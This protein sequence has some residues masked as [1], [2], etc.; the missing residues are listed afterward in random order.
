MRSKLEAEQ[1]IAGLWPAMDDPARHSFSDLTLCEAAKSRAV[2][3]RAWHTRDPGRRTPDRA[4]G[5]RS[6]HSHV[7]RISRHKAHL[8]RDGGQL[9]D[10]ESSRGTCE[11]MDLETGARRDRVPPGLV[12]GALAAGLALAGCGDSN[13]TKSQ[14]RPTSRPS[15]A[16]AAT[17]TATPA[18]SA[19]AGIPFR[20]RASDGVSLHGR[21]VPGGG[22]RAP[23]V[24]LV[25]E[26]DGGPAQFE[27]LIGYL[28][29]KG[30]ASLAY[31][32]R[33]G[34]A[35]LDETKNARDVAG[36]VLALRRDRRIDPRR[37]AVVG[38]SIGASAAA[39]FSFTRVGRSVQAIV[40]LSPADFNDSP[41]RG[42]RPRDVLLVADAAERPA[43]EF[44]ADGSPG[45]T[46][47]TAPVNA[48]GVALLP[49]ERVRDQVLSWLADRLDH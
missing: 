11:D 27:L 3:R 8:T 6:G 37:I 21:L 47:R 31:L 45:I 10:T 17:A 34:P 39:Y 35:R 24:V 23:G 9:R 26:S 49:D 38:A 13:A 28:H 20:F 33:A 14:S 2:A 43:A 4:A 41:P 44:I 15:A 12:A 1:A 18:P 32:S 40:G 25:H 5:A 30:Y 22:R 19:P 7:A 48:H 46:V 16:T 42:R 29:A 36:A